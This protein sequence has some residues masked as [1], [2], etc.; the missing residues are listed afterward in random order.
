MDRRRFLRVTGLGSLGFAAA[1]ASGCRLVGL[2]GGSMSTKDLRPVVVST[3]RHGILANRAAYALL[4]EGGE[5]L[6]AVEAGVRVTESDPE[7]TSVG[8]GGNPNRDGVVELDAAIM[9]GRDL[10]I[11]SV[12]GL[13]GILHPISVARRVMEQTPHVLLVG[14]GARQFALA[15]GFE[16][17]ELLTDAARTRWE[18]HRAK[19]GAE[20]RPE[21]NHDPDHHDPDNHDT[22]GMVAVDANG[23]VAASCTTSGWAWK[24]PG[25]VG[26]S[27]IVGAGLYCDNE[28]GGATATGDGEEVIRVCG[29]YQ[30]VEY[31]REG[32]EPQRAVERVLER[33]LARHERAMPR[34]KRSKIPAVSLIALRKDGQVGYASTIPQFQVAVSVAGAH[35]LYDSPVVT[36]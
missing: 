1:A 17:Q 23:D 4:A 21:D 31:L 10:S 3:W 26:D 2:E 16:S 35:V 29:S 22:I 8:L 7:V 24:L 13:Q 28:V 14:E 15:Q 27:P 32:W 33:V 12:A 36:R 9:D 30:V 5:A 6:D 18:K 34:S 25:R 11:G 19:V 20:V